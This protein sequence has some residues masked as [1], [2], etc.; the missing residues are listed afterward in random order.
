MGNLEDAFIESVM[1]NDPYQDAW[2]QEDEDIV[3]E[4]GTYPA[5][6]I[7]LSKQNI[8]T[9]HNVHAD[10]FKPTYQIAKGKFKGA[11]ISDKGIWRFRSEPSNRRNGSKRG[12]I[13][14]KSILDILDIQLESVEVDGVILKRLPELTLDNIS[15]KKVLV[16][17]QEDDYKSNYGKLSNKVALLN[18]KWEDVGGKNN[19]DS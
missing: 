6:V 15:G 9:R 4:D 14:Y 16:D 5:T 10:L 1:G 11:T 13:I 18:S 2:Y 17:V 3:V 8:I 19:A 7:N 12:N